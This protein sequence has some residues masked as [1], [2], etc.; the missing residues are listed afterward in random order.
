MPPTQSILREAIEAGA[1]SQVAGGVFLPSEVW[2]ELLLEHQDRVTYQQALEE[3][4][5][6]PR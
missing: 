6:A 1:V 4:F 5:Q 3:S 2:R